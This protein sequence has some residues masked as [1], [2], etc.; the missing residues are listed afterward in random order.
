MRSLMRMTKNLNEVGNKAIILIK[1]WARQ[2]SACFTA[3]LL[4]LYF[5]FAVGLEGTS[6]R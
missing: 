5:L 2:G 4:A 1:D 3:L 6:L